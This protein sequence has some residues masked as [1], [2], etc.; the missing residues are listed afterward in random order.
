MRYWKESM[1]SFQKNNS[2]SAFGKPWSVFFPCTKELLRTEIRERRKLLRSTGWRPQS[3]GGSSKAACLLQID[4]SLA[5]LHGLSMLA[6][7]RTLLRRRR[8]WELIYGI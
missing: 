6:R 1:Q 4:A 5:A 7:A 3:W 8:I 2:L